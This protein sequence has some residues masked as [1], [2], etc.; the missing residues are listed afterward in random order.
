MD[1]SKV[2]IVKRSLFS[3]ALGRNLKLQLILLLIV[4]VAVVARVVPL[5]MQKRIINE[6]IK[7]QKI[8]LL[9]LYCGIY[10]AA[11]V[12]ASGLKFGINALQ[13][14]I[15]Q[16]TLAE[17]RRHL[18]SHIL[19]LPQ[20]FFRKTQSGLIVSSMTSELATAGDF[21]GMAVAVPLS[22]VL[23]LLA[24]AGYLFWLNPLLAAVSFSI[25][26]AVLLVVPLL[27]K[28]VNHYN[29]KRVDANRSYSGRIGESVEGIHEIKA[30]A[31]FNIESR[32]LGE[33]I[34]RLRKIRII[35]NLYRFAVKV[36]N[37]LF[38]NFSRFL[39]FALGGYLALKGRLDLGALVAFLSAQE[40]LYVPWKELIRFYQVYQT[41]AVT[42]QRTMDYYAVEAEKGPESVDRDL[43]RLKGRMAVDN[44]SFS[45]AEGKPLLQGVSFSLAPGEHMALV[46]GS[47]SGKSTLVNCLMGLYPIFD[48]HYELDGRS[49]SELDR[50][51]L[52]A[53]IGFVFQS[54][55]IF[56]GSIQENLLYAC[57]AVSG[58]SNK[59]DQK[60]LPNL[61]QQ[62]EVLQQTGLFID[63][64]GFGLSARFEPETHHHLQD[65][66]LA[67]R[68]EFHAD[69]AA[70]AKNDVEVFDADR[71]LYHASIAENLLFGTAVDSRFSDEKLARNTIFTRLLLEEQLMDPL[72]DL[73]HRFAERILSDFGNLSILPRNIPVLFEE[74]EILQQAVKKAA[75]L[76]PQ[77]LPE[78]HRRRLL[79]LSLRYIPAAHDM[80]T[81]SESLTD[82]IVAARQIVMKTLE[83]E[84]PGAVIFYKPEV[85]I[86]GASILENIIF[87]RITSD[88]ADVKIRIHRNI[89]R[90]LV[91]EAL[92]EAVLEIGMTFQVGRG[93][94]NLS[95][96]QRQKLA[97]ARAFLKKPSILL[98]DEATASLDNQSQDRVQKVLES[99]WKGKSTLVAVVHRLDIIEGYDKIAVM[100]DGR[101]AE[102]GTYE[103]L[104]E[105]K[106]L[107]YELVHKT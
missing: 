1:K 54:P 40:K 57:R 69:H 23:T 22:N 31:A 9:V 41:A 74:M 50:R 37:N 7:Q 80:V 51:D 10:L 67:V 8:D 17:M 85:Y 47:G 61:N 45:T 99:R 32:Y 2:P 26:P 34:E 12:T 4:I 75:Q 44:L 103:D 11:F 83:E 59:A 79:G 81:L 18:Y 102:M 82:R 42:Y 89:N 56:S 107:L 65:A 97:L 52:S 71:Y 63:V 5:E 101:I 88:D 28:R 38:T 58:F 20:S 98:L 16:N 6:A 64:L 104:M 33:R 48:G 3:W 78:K 49:A 93:G 100:Q 96:G 87:G 15:G 39:I 86:P 25:Y 84:A 91:E 62:V 60:T 105:K 55:A 66:V 13:S 53:N 27:Q 24:F 95:G 36:V 90:L 29:K 46:G 14:I 68:V 35:W 72:I 106:E 76:P 77:N 19:T 92:L 70:E 43:V 94:D 73:G 21:V 30:N